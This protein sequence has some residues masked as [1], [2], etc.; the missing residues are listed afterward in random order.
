M[1]EIKTVAITLRKPAGSDTVG[2]AAYIHYTCV[3]GMLRVVDPA[4]V[5]LRSSNGEPLMRRLG[6]DD[7]PRVVAAQLGHEYHRQH[8]GDQERG[9]WRSMPPRPNVPW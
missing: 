1:S 5:Q 8:F 7:S 4:G 2:E 6:P 3:D 9:F